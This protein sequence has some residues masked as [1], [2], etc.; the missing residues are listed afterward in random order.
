[1]AGQAARVG[2]T[3]DGRG[4][5]RLLLNGKTVGRGAAKGGLK[6]V[7]ETGFTIGAWVDGA[8]HPFSGEIRGVEIARGALNPKA[9]AKVR[10]AERRL[11]QG[12]KRKTGLKRVEMRLNPNYGNSRLQP[13]KDIMNAA[14]VEKLSDL[15]TLDITTRT[16]MTP[17]RVIVAAKTAPTRKPNWGKLAKDL[18]LGSAAAKR[19]LLA[20]TLA[21]RNSVKAL[22]LVVDGD[23]GPSAPRASAGAGPGAGS[24]AGAARV[25]APVAGLAEAG[26]AFARPTTATP[27]A[28]SR[29]AA[30]PDL[31]V[32]ARAAAA[33]RMR[34]D[35]ALPAETL[36][37]A[38][39]LRRSAKPV[40]LSET[41]ELKRGK[42]KVLDPDVALRLEAA[43]PAL[44]ATPAAPRMQILS[45]NTIPIDS[46]VMIGQTIDLT[47]TQ[48]VIEPTVAT[49]YLIAERLICG[50][51]ARITWRRP[52]GT[53]PARLDDA[54][55]NGRGWSGIHTKS[56]SRD[57]LD[58]EDGRSGVSGVEGADGLRAPNLEI[59]VKDL[60]AMPDLDLN[61]EDGRRGGRGQRGGRGGAGA[62]GSRGKRAWF[63]GWHCT[64]DPGDGG[65]GGDGGFGGRGG[66]GGDG[67]NGGDISIGVLEDTLEETVTAR[68][69]KIKNQG[70]AAGR[71]GAG[72]AGGSGGSGGRPGVGETCK[73]ADHGHPG[74]RGQPGATG[75][76]GSHGGHDGELEFMEFTEDEWDALLTR[77]WIAEV[78]P[79]HVFPGDRL[80]LRGSRF[81]PGDAVVLNGTSL[82]GTVNAD[83]SLSTDVPLGIAGG[84]KTVFVR[85]QDGTESNRANVWIKPQLSAFSGALTPGATI[86]LSGR[87]FLAGAA[88]LVDGDAAESTRLSATS[89]EFTMPGTGG[90]GSSGGSAT[91][92]VRNPDGLV[93][94]LRAASI[95]RVLEIPFRYGQHNLSFPNFTDGVP[96]WGTFEDTYGA[97]EV[98]HELLDPVFG[99]PV[100]TAGF[101]AFYNEFLKGTANGGLAT[102][103]CTSLAALVADR[104]WQGH[105][106]APS[107]TK[108]QNHKFL[109]AL[110]G[111]LLSRESLI[112]F[113][114]QGR[115]G[116]TRVEITARE[117]EATFLRGTDRQNAPMLFFIPSGAAWDAGYFDRLS[118]SHCILPYRFVYPAGHPGPQLAPGGATTIT[119][120]DGVEMFCWDCN[121]PENPECRVR[122]F[123]SGG[124]LHYEYFNGGTSVQ[125]SSA[126]GVT[127]GMMTNGAYHL[128]DH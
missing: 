8:K 52:G 62:D 48:L 70:G 21:N 54:D 66:R 115:V 86:R 58:G 111:K 127:L 100:L 69:F 112:H 73:D 26:Q 110:H 126:D 71:G 119:S 101:Y 39:V 124:A 98:W 16:V 43:E 53:T 83:E 90:A 78:S 104:F 79:T 5:M 91:L 97:A 122:F 120:L 121:R 81:S 36:S 9:A 41:L 80:T 34:A 10:S 59:W 92:Q 29:R 3:R 27:A 1:A 102:G 13:I 57:G 6:P 63:F 94:N 44:W 76:D 45:L 25:A 106:D 56:G 24:G 87:A 19:T 82:P 67:G 75:S 38:S 72:G 89:I 123:D 4:R 50:P 93:S 12:F 128:A 61:G 40:A 68:A 14:G 74:A 117:I 30:G 113:H 46:A 85:R 64:S 49:L 11:A 55:L 99:H 95:P 116:L 96:D 28:L 65:D 22:G 2:F 77:P 37:A 47:N 31:S 118:D 84:I 51:G 7:G 107:L 17:G 114:D 23:F 103:F 109:T 125:F 32:A 15:Q 88:V 20:G 108:L 33:P 35:I 42:I 60:S 105:S 18:T